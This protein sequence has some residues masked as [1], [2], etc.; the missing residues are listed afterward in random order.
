MRLIDCISTSNGAHRSIDMRSS[1]HKYESELT[2]DSSREEAWWRPYYH[3]AHTQRPKGYRHVF[4]SQLS[5]ERHVQEAL[6]ALRSDV[7]KAGA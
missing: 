6:T 2:M 5:V 1:F 3:R 4:A 7:S